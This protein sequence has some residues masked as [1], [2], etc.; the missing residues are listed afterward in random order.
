M[1][2]GSAIPSTSREDFY[3]VPVCIPPVSI[4]GKFG[5]IV[6]HLFRK[7]YENDGESQTLAIIR[8]TL[9]PKLLSGEISTAQAEKAMK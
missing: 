6:E 4:Q 5:E 7:K 1:D 3:G 8:D 9:L 2:S